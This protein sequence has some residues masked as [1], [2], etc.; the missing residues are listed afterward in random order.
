[1]YCVECFNKFNTNN[2]NPCPFC[3]YSFTEHY[4]LNY[5][6]MMKHIKGGG[7]RYN[8]NIHAF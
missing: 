6:E 2:L 5:N 1:M 8:F 7:F 3:R 4:E